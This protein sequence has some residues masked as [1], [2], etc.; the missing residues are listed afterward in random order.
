MDRRDLYELLIF[1]EVAEAGSF[2]RAA[3]RMG[4]AQSG[5]SQ[6]VA[7]LEARL[8]VPL[9]VR[10]TRSARLTDEGRTLLEQVDPLY[11]RSQTAWNAPKLDVKTLAVCYESQQWSTQLERYYYRCSLHFW[12]DTRM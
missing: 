7:A 4:R 6:S 9:L 12:I 3:A 8:G 11:A 1:Q 5:V 2:T 10:S